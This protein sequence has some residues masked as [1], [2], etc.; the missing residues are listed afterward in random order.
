MPPYEQDGFERVE[1]PALRWDESTNSTLQINMQYNLSCTMKN[2]DSIMF[3][4]PY[5]G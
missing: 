2:H 5:L 3:G 1:L 4:Y